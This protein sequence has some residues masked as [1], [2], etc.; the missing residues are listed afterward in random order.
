ML[1][2]YS[3]WGCHLCEEAELLL[4]Q[5]GAEF[6]VIDIVDDP[7]AFALYRTSIPVVVSV[8]VATDVSAAPQLFWPFDQYRLAAFLDDLT[9]A[10]EG[11]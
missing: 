6:R 2:L 7:H 9:L 1:I 5:T 11:N 10:S 3:T 4:R 8:K